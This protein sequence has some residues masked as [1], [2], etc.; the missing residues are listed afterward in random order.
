MASLFQKEILDKTLELFNPKSVLD[1]G[2]GVGKSLDYFLSKGIFVTGV[3][4][5][6]IAI[7][8]SNHPEL[9]IQ[10]NLEWELNL[11]KKFDLVWSLEFVEHI[12]PK[13][14]NNLL[15]TFSNHS[16]K[17]VMSAAQPRQRGFWHLNEQPETY[18]IKQFEKYGY[19]FNK[20]K[21]EELR[22]IEPLDL[23]KNMLVF[24]R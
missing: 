10:Y 9:I 8:K 13:F 1:L 15:K 17:I 23:T 4:G 20:D 6:K 5:S 14:V 18:W 21:T 12:H 16:D 24:E 22:E 11:N 7:R 2:C 3:E 19:R